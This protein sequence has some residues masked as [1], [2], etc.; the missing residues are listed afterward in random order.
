MLDELVEWTCFLSVL[1]WSLTPDVWGSLFAQFWPGWTRSPEGERERSTAICRQERMAV[2]VCG[3][4]M[5]VT[6]FLSSQQSHQT[7]RPNR[8]KP[9]LW[10]KR[11]GFENKH[12][13]CL[14]SFAPPPPPPQW[15]RVPGLHYSLYSSLLQA[16]RK[17]SR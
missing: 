5:T 15:P 11:V 16:W 9:S 6:K 17:E 3:G 2:M 1:P 8:H 14:S 7:V 4:I 10:D 12:R 13:Q